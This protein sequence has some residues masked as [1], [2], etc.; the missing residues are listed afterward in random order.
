MNGRAFPA[1]GSYAPH[2]GLE[3]YRYG[4]VA[5]ALSVGHK[6]FAAAEQNRVRRRSMQFRICAS[7]VGV[8]RDED[9]AA[10]QL[11]LHVMQG[12]ER[13]ASHNIFVTI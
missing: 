3:G 10:A 1:P 9:I 11:L 8:R 2:G 13:C 6:N 12:V 5:M 7:V 4:D